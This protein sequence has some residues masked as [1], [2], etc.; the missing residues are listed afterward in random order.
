[1]TRHCARPVTTLSAGLAVHQAGQSAE[2]TFGNADA[3]LY[4]AKLSGRDRL[5][6]HNDERNA[7]RFITV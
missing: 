6:V 7:P 1:M 3:A 5:V 4:S 2:R